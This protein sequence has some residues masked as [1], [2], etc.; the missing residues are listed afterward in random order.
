MTDVLIRNV[1]EDDLQRI[2]ERASRMG[3]SRN[4]FLRRRISQEA[5]LAAAPTRPLTRDDFVRFS[6]LAAD[7]L[8][9]DVMRQAWS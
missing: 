5:A 1:P 2:D 9:E 7:L 4:E 3:L 6:E 8:D